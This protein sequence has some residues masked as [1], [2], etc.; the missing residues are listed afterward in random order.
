MRA[1]H[2]IYFHAAAAFVD[3]GGRV[4]HENNCHGRLGIFGGNNITRLSE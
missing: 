3:E 2:D 1:K 4:P